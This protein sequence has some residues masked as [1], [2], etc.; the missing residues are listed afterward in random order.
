[1][2]IKNSEY[3][4]HIYKIYIK[5]YKIQNILYHTQTHTHTHTHTQEVIENVANHLWG[6][7]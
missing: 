1:M 6:M 7:K 2:L 3:I 5:M 4:K